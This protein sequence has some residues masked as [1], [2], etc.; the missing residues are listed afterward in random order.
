MPEARHSIFISYARRDGTA[1]AL[2]LQKDLTGDG[3]D[4]WLD[5]QRVEGGASWTVEIEEAIDRAEFVL[6]LLSPGSFTSEICRAEQ[7]RSLRKGRCVI[8]AARRAGIRCPAALRA[9][10]SI[11]ILRVNRITPRLS[12]LCS[13]TSRREREPN[14]PSAIAPQLR[15]SLQPLPRSLITSTGRRR[16][17]LLRDALF[18]ADGHRSIALTALEGM[19]GI[20][21]TVLAQAIVK[22]EIVR[23]AFPDG[24]VWITVGRETAHDFTPR[25]REITKVLGGGSDETVSPD[26]LY[27][28]TIASRAALIVIDDIWS[29]ADLD[30]FLAESPRSRFLFTTR[31]ASIARFSGARE[32]RVDLLET[33]QARELLA[34]WA[35]LEVGLFTARG[36]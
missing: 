6:A 29:K 15:L 36:R 30:P 13:A 16:F 9:G 28:T 11:A 22:D 25:L 3:F 35:S 2:R 33:A 4:V 34:R 5:T 14:F 8:S 24:L 17:E 12:S 21:K 7:L 31:D 10:K 27:R 32:F 1:L 23:H 19:G 26:T 20:G 18:E